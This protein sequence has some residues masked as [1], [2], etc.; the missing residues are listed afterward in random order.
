[1]LLKLILFD[2]DRALLALREDDGGPIVALCQ[3]DLELNEDI[4]T[5]LDSQDSG[6]KS[7]FPIAVIQSSGSWAKTL[8]AHE[9]YTIEEGAETVFEQ[10]TSYD[11]GVIQKW[12]IKATGRGD[13]LDLAVGLVIENYDDIHPTHQ[14]HFPNGRDGPPLELTLPRWR[15][16]DAYER[17]INYLRDE[18]KDD[19]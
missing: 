8:K 6:W 16:I 2:C 3:G 11:M 13:L 18:E 7:T 5:F 4:Q 1:V 14:A 17:A 10:Y 15:F 19:L 9:F 12:E